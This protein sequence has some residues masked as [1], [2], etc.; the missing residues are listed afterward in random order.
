MS[1]PDIKSFDYH[2]NWRSRGR[3]PGRHASTQRGM[4]MEFRG[5]TTLLS[6][7]DP[8][9]IDIRQTIRDPMEQV[10]VRLFNQKSATPVFVIC[11]LSGS[12]N[13]GAK[14]RKIKLAAEIAE[15]IAQ[16]ASEHHDPFG[17]IGFDEKVRE[18]W[19]SATS[20][21]SHHAIAMA[22]SLKDFHPAPVNCNGITE[23]YRYLPRERSLVF[24]I[25]DFHMPNDLLEEGLS[26]LLR[27]YIV[28]VVLWDAAEYRNLPE[29]GLANVTDA[30]TGEKRTL[31]IR[32]EL[33]EKIVQ[34]FE[35]RREEIYELFMR[36]DMP[37]FY[38]EGDFDPNLMT[39]YFHQSVAA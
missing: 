30:E 32:K 3:N 29:F 14:K 2:I 4:G 18:D 35:A 11:D 36:F 8:R 27:H 13:F 1:I 6:Y 26:N 28:P 37:P 12:M 23:V 20:Y 39:E 19:I 25:S 21:K 24:L 16:S 5:H 9:R 34:S 33:R 15:S 22:E 17:F 38:V 31:F 7:P 10:Y